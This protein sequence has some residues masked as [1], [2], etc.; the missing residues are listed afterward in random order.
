MDNK[1]TSNLAQINPEFRNFIDQQVLP[2]T[3][4]E[5]SKFW[6]D[7]SSLIE[8]FAGRNRELLAIRLQMQERIDAWHLANSGEK[9]SPD[10]Y[11]AFLEEIEYLL[12]VGEDFQI[13][14]EN[15]DAEIATIAGP[16]LV[17]PLKNAR[18]ALN[19]A[20]ARWGSL[21]DALYGSDVISTEGELQPGSEYNSLR[22]AKVIKYG[23]SFLDQMAPL[24]EGSHQQVAA[25]RVHLQQLQVTLYDGTSF[26]LAQ[27]EKFVAF[28]GEQESPTSILLKNNGLHVEIQIDRQGQ[29]GRND[30]AGINDI[31][32]EAAISTIMDCEDSVAAVDTADKLEIYRNW[33][34]LMQGTLNAQFIKHGKPVTRRL[35]PD[36]NYTAADGSDYK[37]AGRSLLFNRNVGH[38]MDIDIMRDSQGKPVPEGILDAVVTALIGSLDLLSERHYPNSETG[39]IYIVKP[40]MHGPD[41]VSFTCELFSRIEDMLSL[42][43]YTLKLGIMDEERRTTVNLKECIRRAQQRLVFINTG[44]LD[45]TGDEIHTSMEAGPF[46]PKAQIKSQAWIKAYEDRNVDIGLACGLAGRAQI[47]KGMWTMPDEMA[48]MM[49]IKIEHPRAGATTAWVP[50]PTAAVLH[51]MH[52]HRVDVFEIHQQI[53]NREPASLADILTIPLLDQSTE[54][55]ADQI[56]RELENNIQ[57]ILG[58]VVRWVEQGIGCSKVPDI[59]DIG[60][61]EDRATLRISA[62]HVANWLHHGLCSEQQVSEIMRRMALVVDAQ[63]EGNPDYSNMSDGFE[64]SA[65]FSAAYDLIMKSHELPN[66]YTEPVLHD[67]RIGVKKRSF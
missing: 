13:Q 32:L 5:R 3:A 28:H 64:A 26:G 24:S 10:T 60:L 12:P 9:F 53:K 15:V 33:L 50:S 18:F 46:M 55:S 43:R 59:N 36:R 29:V 49:A 66:G 48:Q 47:G 65:G 57:G 41:E 27:P 8:E 31:I 34:G 37:V 16:Q 51:A 25:Y 7:L 44:F 63:N 35:N 62:K 14:T 54:L 17:V 23:H 45:R 1:A 22:G 67:Y 6:R 30:P 38:L 40:K 39:S 19:A 56:E 2:L 11:R 42:N 4:L 61:M 20:N 58:Y 21:Y 52:Y